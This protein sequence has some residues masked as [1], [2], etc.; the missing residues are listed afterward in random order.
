MARY[1]PQIDGLRTI[2]AFSV[3][4]YHCLPPLFPGGYLGVD[5]FFVISGY[6]MMSA[7]THAEIWKSRASFFAFYRRRL[8]RLAPLLI[9]V[10]LSLA[11]FLSLTGKVIYWQQDVL[12][13]LTYTSNLTSLAG[14]PPLWMLHTWSLSQEMQFYLLVPFLLL[15]ISGFSDRTKF[16]GF[17]LLYAAIIIW[18]YFI[19]QKHGL[20]RFYFDPIAQNR[21]DNRLRARL[22]ATL[23]H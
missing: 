3:V 18:R 11:L 1:L 4:A 9:T 21:P 7:T 17:I 5:I 10:V 16:Y 6:L 2:A 15:A 8:L 12:S 22:C 23:F 14:Q 19:I 20:D 13:V